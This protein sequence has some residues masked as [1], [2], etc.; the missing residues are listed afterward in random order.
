VQ[1]HKAVEVCTTLIRSHI[2]KVNEKEE[3]KNILTH[4]CVESEEVEGVLVSEVGYIKSWASVIDDVEACD[5]YDVLMW[6]DEIKDTWAAQTINKNDGSYDKRGRAIKC[7]EEL[8][9]GIDFVHK[10]EF[11]MV[12]K[13]YEDIIGYLQ[14]NLK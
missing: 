5:G 14:D 9:S 13:T 11:Y 1:F 12:G 6:F 3:A 4:K 10:G 2:A 8:P 7:V